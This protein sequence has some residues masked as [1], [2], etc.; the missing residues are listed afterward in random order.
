MLRQLSGHAGAG[1]QLAAQD[2]M[3]LFHLM[4]EISDNSARRWLGRVTLG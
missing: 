1:R 3:E 2:A 4:S